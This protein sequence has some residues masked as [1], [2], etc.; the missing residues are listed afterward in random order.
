M[1][2][3]MGKFADYYKESPAELKGFL[4]NLESLVSE[5]RKTYYKILTK[6]DFLEDK[7]NHPEFGVDAL[8]RD[9][10]LIDDPKILDSLEE[11]EKLET[12]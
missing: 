9:Y 6:F 11:D 5:D 3:Y 7:I 4:G 8:I 2:R 12:E 10:D 1:A